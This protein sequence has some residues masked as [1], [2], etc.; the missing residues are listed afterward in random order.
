MN[1]QKLFRGVLWGILVALLLVGCSAPAND[2]P[3]ITFDGSTCTYKGL[4]ELTV[5]EH[6][7]VVKK[8]T[9]DNFSIIIADLLDGH[10][11]QDLENRIK[12]QGHVWDESGSNW[13]DWFDAR[14]NIRFV[15]FE[16]DDSKGEERITLYI[17]REG[18]YAI[19][20]YNTSDE[21]MWPCAPLKVVAAPSE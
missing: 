14:G 3:V 17:Q 11:F 1:G 12:E 9:E 10:T 16:K 19:A 15:A 21:T 4:S 5:G 20:I 7:F 6:P 8:Q 13:P 2:Q 18:T